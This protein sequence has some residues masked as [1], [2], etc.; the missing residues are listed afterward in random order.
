MAGM[1][2]W[3]LC[4]TLLVINVLWNLRNFPVDGRVSL[5]LSWQWFFGSVIGCLLKRNVF[6]TSWYAHMQ[7]LPLFTNVSQ[8]KNNYCGFV[9]P[10]RLLRK[11]TKG[12]HEYVW[13][14]TSWLDWIGS[15]PGHFA[16]KSFTIYCCTGTIHIWK[17]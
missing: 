10:I 9:F 16:P 8:H 2:L 5:S 14:L 4:R 13:P 15:S 1:A 3:V 17:Q 6:C 7:T 11:R 12:S